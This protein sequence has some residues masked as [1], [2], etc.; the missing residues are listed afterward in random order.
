MVEDLPDDRADDRGDRPFSASRRCSCRP[1]RGYLPWHRELILLTGGL[2]LAAAV[3]LGTRRFRRTT[4][5]WL[6][7]YFV[8][9]LPAHF[10]VAINRVPM[11]G[12]DDPL[13]LWGRIPFQAVFLYA[14][15][16]IAKEESR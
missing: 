5:W 8:A 12:V 4:A 2:E 1:C 3:G 15:S 7:A 14:S 6:I 13:W 9:I 16:L 11:F 10:H